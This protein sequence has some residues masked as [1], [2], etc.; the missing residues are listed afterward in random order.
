MTKRLPP[1]RIAEIKARF[2]KA[3]WVPYFDELLSHIDAIEAELC[4]FKMK[5]V[6]AETREEKLR[7]QLEL[8][9]RERM[10]QVDKW[11]E[12]AGKTETELAEAKVE[13]ARLKDDVIEARLAARVIAHS[14]DHDS[15]PPE[16]ALAIARTFTARGEKK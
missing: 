15:R 2:A 4:V 9:H 12:I 8:S 5:A 11:V 3:G 1:E 7:E 6:G 16:G 14:W 13:I 10:H